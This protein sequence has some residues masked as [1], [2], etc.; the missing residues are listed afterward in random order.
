MPVSAIML[1]KSKQRRYLAKKD[2]QWQQELE[3]YGHS[4]D[5]EAIHRLRLA[6]KKIKAFAQFSSACSGRD[7]MKDF[8]LLKKMY[9][10][11]GV[12]RDAGNHLYLLEQAHPAPAF[13]KQEQEQLRQDAAESFIN[14][15]GTYRKKG[16]KAA[17]RMLTDV[18][19]IR[20]GCVK[21]WYAA[22]LIKIAILLNA[23]GDELHQARKEIKS[24][25]YMLSLL[26]SRLVKELRLDRDYLDKL[27]DA[28]GQW[29]DALIVTTAWA[30]KELTGAQAMLSECRAKESAVRVLADEFYHRVHVDD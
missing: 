24:L 23:S 10:Q 8:N 28:I 3:A 26:P 29:H 18:R 6:V 15:I 14:H 16:K 27:Q 17:R 13:L 30:E 12:I 20:L 9:R 22:E 11:A 21:D 19:T 25:L 5:P 4:R 7:T 2:K 1:K